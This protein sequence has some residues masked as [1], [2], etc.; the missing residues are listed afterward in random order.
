MVWLMGKPDIARKRICCNGKEGGKL[1]LKEEMLKD[2]KRTIERQRH[3]IAAQ[4]WII[5]LLLVLAVLL[6]A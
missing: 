6:A 1:T 4:W 3:Q 5:V 2:L